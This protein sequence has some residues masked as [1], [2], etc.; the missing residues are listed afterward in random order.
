MKKNIT[1]ISAFLIA[2]LG[3]Y[4]CSEEGYEDYSPYESKTKELSGDWYVSVYDESGNDNL[5]GYFLFSTYNTAEDNASMWVDDHNSVFPLKAIV[6]ANVDELTF[7][8]QN[9]ENVYDEEGA[10]TVSEGKVFKDGGMASNTKAVVDSVAFKVT[11][12]NDE[13]TYLVAGF[14]RSGFLEDEH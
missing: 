4:G 5:T 9:T 12:A 8:G 13:N 3:F 1:I 2:A 7:S 10:A 11:F 14:K 6:S